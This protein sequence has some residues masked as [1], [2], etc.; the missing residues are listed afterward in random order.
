MK[1]LFSLLAIIGI[2]LASNCTRNPENN[3]AVTGIW[4]DV[5]ISTA[6]DTQKEVELRQE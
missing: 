2:I 1:K 3:Y 5:E 6:T 4:S